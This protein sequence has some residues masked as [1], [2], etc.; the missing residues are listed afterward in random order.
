MERPW[1]RSFNW[2]MAATCILISV[3]GVVL[4]HSAD[5]RDPSAAGEWH[6]QIIYVVIGIVVMALCAATDYHR[7]QR[8]AVPLYVANLG[9]LAFVLR[10][11]HSALGA[12]RWISLGPLGAFQP[13]EPAKLILAITI[14][15][16][17]A[18]WPTIGPREMLLTI[19]AVAVP[20]L[21]ILKQP[22]LGTTLVV[23]AMLT[24]Q[25]FF[26]V[27]NAGYFLAYAAVVG[28]IGAFVVGTNVVLKPF[29]RDRLLVFL[30]P[31]ADPEGAGWNL[32]QSK[33]AVGSG[34]LFGK[35]LYHGTQTQ[36]NFVPE[37]SR[38]FI[39]TVLGEELGYIGTISLIVAY[40]VILLG[41]IL[42]MLAAR[43]RFGFLLAAG[44]IAML[45]FHVTVN[46]G[47]TI[48]IMPITGIPLPFMSYGGSAVITDFA[49]IGV[50]LNIHLQ[51]DKL[52]F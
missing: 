24:A 7:W 51:R 31:N 3:L 49:A 23:V 16:L 12:V 4:I 47:M 19:G 26:G 37:H 6:R 46:V 11:G 39:F 44:L 20:A 28:A 8:W 36:L 2:T 38:D 18:R 32:N 21:L 13:S 17:L 30:H 9:L 45:A 34:E 40:A 10:G 42:A 25:L 41:G 15:S 27:A 29:Q 14:A 1:Y 43:D 5:L 48:G 50:L 35:G 22:D 52:V 33:I